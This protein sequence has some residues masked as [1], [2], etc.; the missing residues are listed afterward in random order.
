MTLARGLRFPQPGAARGRA[1][2][3]RHAG[4]NLSLHAGR[5]RRVHRR[6]RSHVWL[7]SALASVTELQSAIQGAAPS[8]QITLSYFQDPGDANVIDQVKALGLDYVKGRDIRF[9]I[10]CFDNEAQLCAPI[11]P[12]TL[13]LTRVMTEVSF[14]A[15]G[16]RDRSISVGF[17]T[18]GQYRNAARRLQFT[19]E[20]H[21]ALVGSENPSLSL[22][23]TTDFQPV[24]L[25][26]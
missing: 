12:P 18:Q 25:F 1:G 14:S 8:G 13:W 9:Y 19:P 16:P 2:R 17:E 22:R 4:W 15:S 11:Y 20:G 21:A 23:P 3:A 10:Q 24:P 6:G 7:G 5:G 26:G